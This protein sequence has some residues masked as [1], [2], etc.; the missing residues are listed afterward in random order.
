LI[1]KENSFII[2]IRVVLAQISKIK[3]ITNARQGYYKIH[4]KSTGEENRQRGTCQPLIEKV[5][6]TPWKREVEVSSS[7]SLM[8]ISPAKGYDVLGLR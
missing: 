2:E 5:S 4:I 1:I 6:S 3:E 8:E 7:N